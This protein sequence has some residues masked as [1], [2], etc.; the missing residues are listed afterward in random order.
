MKKSFLER[1]GE[2]KTFYTEEIETTKHKTVKRQGLS[3]DK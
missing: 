3:E 1:K 2:G